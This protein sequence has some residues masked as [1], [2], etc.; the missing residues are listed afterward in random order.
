LGLAKQGVYTPRRF[1]FSQNHK[2]QLLAR[3]I[4][5]FLDTERYLQAL[6]VAKLQNHGPSAMNSKGFRRQ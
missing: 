1:F 2:C 3:H 6:S 5:G 4:D